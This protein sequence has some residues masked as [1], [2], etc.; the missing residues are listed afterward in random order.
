MDKDRAPKQTSNK[1][2]ETLKFLKEQMAEPMPEAIEIKEFLQNDSLTDIKN[3]HNFI[4]YLFTRN[5][6]DYRLAL[7]NLVEPTLKEPNVK[8]VINNGKNTKEKHIKKFSDG[9]DFF[10]LL[11]SMEDGKI[12]I[13]GFKTSKLN[14]IKKELERADII[15][16]FIRQGS[17]QEKISRL[18]LPN[19]GIIQQNKTKSQAK[20]HTNRTND[21]EMEL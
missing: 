2:D 11:A 1:V 15:Q 4:E 13:T 20:S 7:I 3:K 21:N 19:S 6:N 12:L 8:I 9:K 17:K 10:Y 5:D 14:T 16:T 18:G